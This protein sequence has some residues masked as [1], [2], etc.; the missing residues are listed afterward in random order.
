MPSRRS[1]NILGSI[2]SRF[3]PTH[4]PSLSLYVLGQWV[5]RSCCVLLSHRDITKIWYATEMWRV[6]ETSSSCTGILKICAVRIISKWLCGLN[7]LLMRPK[8][9]EKFSPKWLCYYSSTGTSSPWPGRSLI[10]GLTPLRCWCTYE[11]RLK[12][13][14]RTKFNAGTRFAK[15]H[16]C[17]KPI[18]LEKK[19]GTM[20]TP[21]YCDRQSFWSAALPSH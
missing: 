21:L 2:T 17:P 10:L 14:R 13:K 16:E 3:L 6:I 8:S 20:K 18:G 11:N 4:T 12:R 1:G 5:Y 15:A 19:N 9:N 7:K